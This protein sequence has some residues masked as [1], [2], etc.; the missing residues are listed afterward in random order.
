MFLLSSLHEVFSCSHDLAIHLK[1]L[2]NNAFGPG[3]Q[4]CHSYT[5][6]SGI[7]AELQG[8]NISW[9]F[10][11]LNYCVMPRTVNKLVMFWSKSNIIS[12]KK[13]NSLIS[14]LKELG[15]NLYC[16][17]LYKHQ[18]KCFHLKKN[19]SSSKH[20]LLMDDFSSSQTKSILHATEKT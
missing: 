9:V 13:V 3:T 6:L 1:F 8:G 5:I 19:S 17:V 7:L 14:C 20:L 18:I 2:N 12:E 15:I 16:K 4:S 11:L 10:F